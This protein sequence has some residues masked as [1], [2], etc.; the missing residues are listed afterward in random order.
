MHQH[1][2]QTAITLCES[3]TLTLDQ[4][5]RQAG[6]TPDR[7]QRTLRTYGVTLPSTEQTHA[8]TEPSPGEMPLVRV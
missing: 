3:G 4:A 2:V 1:A 8:E 7:L 5:A 6:T